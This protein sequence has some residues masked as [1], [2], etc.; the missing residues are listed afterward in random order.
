MKKNASFNL[1]YSLN[2]LS[3]AQYN[4]EPEKRNRQK[5]LLKKDI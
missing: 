3:G 2:L 4:R 5:R 1:Y